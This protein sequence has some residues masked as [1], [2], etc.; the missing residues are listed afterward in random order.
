MRGSRQLLIRDFLSVTTIIAIWF[1]TFVASPDT[2]W[3]F[4]G[5]ALT[6]CAALILRQSFLV[7][8][9]PLVFSANLMLLLNFRVA[10][11]A[12]SAAILIGFIVVFVVAVSE[13][14]IRRTCFKFRTRTNRKGVVFIAIQNGALSGIFVAFQFGLPVLTSC[15]AS[16]FTAFPVPIGNLAYISVFFPLVV[17]TVLGVALG[18]VLGFV[19]DRLIALDFQNRQTPIRTIEQETLG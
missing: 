18:G 1:A 5:A 8:L 16:W 4:L 2:A 9:L 6:F 15:V 17:C 13:F 3:L 11:N 7:F 19:C 14:T 10:L 12:P